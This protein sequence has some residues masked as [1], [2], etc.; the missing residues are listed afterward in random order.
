MEG[1][2]GDAGHR[3]QYPNKR[4]GELQQQNENVSDATADILGGQTRETEQSIQGAKEQ[5][6]Q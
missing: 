4:F 6:F 3:I 1:Q 2:P 5:A